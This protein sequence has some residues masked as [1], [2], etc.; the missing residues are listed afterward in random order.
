MKITKVSA[1]L[2]A[3]LAFGTSQA[4]DNPAFDN[5]FTL[6]FGFIPGGKNFADLSELNTL[7]MAEYSSNYSSYVNQVA[8]GGSPTSVPL[9]PTQLVNP[10]V[11]M[12]FGFELGS[13]FF[14]NSIPIHD[15][16][17]IGIDVTWFELYYASA[18]YETFKAGGYNIDPSKPKVTKGEDIKALSLRPGCKLGLFVSVNP[19]DKLAIDFAFRV[20]PMVNAML[21]TPVTVYEE[22]YSTTK[23]LTGEKA[24]ATYNESVGAGQFGFGLRMVPGIF[25]RYKPFFAGVDFVLGS[26]K[27]TGGL[28]TAATLEDPSLPTQFNLEPS[29]TVQTYKSKLNET[30]LL[31]GFKF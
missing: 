7:N 10:K 24:T 13:M 8:S 5:G 9:E 19:V 31:I 30:R 15:M 2:L 22:S 1:L 17:R 16:V 4:Q 6:K 29:A 18:T 28:A 25:I 20:N 21:M 27:H 3:L 12:G 11:G 26:V 23:F 14:L